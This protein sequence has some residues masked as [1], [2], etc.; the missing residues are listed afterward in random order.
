[1]MAAVSRPPLKPPPPLPT[2]L[3]FQVS[4][5]QTSTLI[6]DAAAATPAAS[7]PS[8]RFK[9]FRT[10]L[11]PPTP[12]REPLAH[13]EVGEAADGG[14]VHRRQPRRHV[15]ERDLLVEHIVDI[16]RERQ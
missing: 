11:A 8:V 3:P 16:Q 2:N 7:R 10:G 12:D 5:S 14:P 15:Q 4:G 9:V 6:S 1:M 13:A